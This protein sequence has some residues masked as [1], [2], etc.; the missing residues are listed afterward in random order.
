MMATN[1][2]ASLRAT[3]NMRSRRFLRM[4]TTQKMVTK[5][6]AVEAAGGAMAVRPPVGG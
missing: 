2:R 3:K 1:I 6:V 4:L 5:F